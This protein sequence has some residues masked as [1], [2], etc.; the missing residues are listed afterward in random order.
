MLKISNTPESV[1]LA[2]LETGVVQ[3]KTYQGCGKAEVNHLI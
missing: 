3:A 1:G 2:L